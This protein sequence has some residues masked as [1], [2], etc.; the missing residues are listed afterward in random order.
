MD[1]SEDIEVCHQMSACLIT[2]VGDVYRIVIPLPHRV[3]REYVELVVSGIGQESIGVV[4]Q[5]DKARYDRLMAQAEATPP[6]MPQP[7]TAE[8]R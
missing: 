1:Y 4:A 6:E 2:Q 3:E 7:G 8:E 5:R